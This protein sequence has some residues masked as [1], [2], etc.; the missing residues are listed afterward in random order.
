MVKKGTDNSASPVSAPLKGGA[1]ALNSGADEP[2]ISDSIKSLWRVRAG[3]LPGSYRGFWRA[4]VEGR[5]RRDARARRTLNRMGWS[6]VVAWEHDARLE[7][8]G[9]ICRLL[10]IIASRA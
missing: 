3:R 2:A 9:P 10:R 7:Y 6:V 8:A 5:R 4:K 1:K